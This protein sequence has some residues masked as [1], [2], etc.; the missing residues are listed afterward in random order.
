VPVW[1]VRTQTSQ[2]ALLPDEVHLEI[3]QF[4]RRVITRAFNEAVCHELAKHIDPSLPGKTLIFCVNDLHA[5]VVVD[6][7]KQAFV[8]KYGSVEDGAVEKITGSVDRPLEA[9]R[10]FRTDRRPCVA[11]TVD[12]LTTGIDVPEIDKLVFLRR[13]RSRILYEQM[14]GRATRLSP[15]LHG[16]AQ[17]KEVFQI[18]DAVDLYAA[19][20]DRTDMK[21]VVVDP[22]LRFEDLVKDLA[23]LKDA[24]HIDQVLGEL[25]TKL[26]RKVKRLDPRVAERLSDEL[27][28]S[29]EDL[30]RT[31]RAAS[32]VEAR[33][34]WLDHPR[35]ADLLDA[36]GVG[37]G[38]DGLYVSSHA[39]EVRRVGDALIAPADAPV[40][41]PA[42]DVTP[43]ALIAA[44][45]TDA[46]VV[47]P[48]TD[49]LHRSVLQSSTRSGG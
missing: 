11:V 34:L 3:D 45:I 44:F 41:N 29:P 20:A 4:H 28:Q 25:V 15:D 10:R 14:L 26:A 18:F 32:P 1:Q 49:G 24:G 42:F 46:G 21:P 7:L 9:I 23:K 12:L 16:A 31:L 40:F 5:D 36:R 13:V 2:L 37:T 43:A 17:A 6:C 35:L 38:I 48:T 19:L 8:A 39:D 27:G 22:S 30:V 33:K 47:R